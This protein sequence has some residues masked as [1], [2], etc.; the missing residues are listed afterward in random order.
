MV[1]KIKHLEDSIQES[2]VQWFNLQYKHLNGLLFHIPNGEY[3]ARIQNKNGDW[4][5]PA[6]VR[7]KKLGARRG[8]AD[9]FLM[10]SNKAYH[11]LWIEF[12]TKTGKL[13]DDQ[14]IFKQLCEHVN[15]KHEV[16]R[17]LD[18]GIISI[19]KYLM[20]I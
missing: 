9:I 7:L 19:K 5:C 2:F 20:N 3:R 10:L 17:S 16:A 18:D 15:Y 1:K 14:K 11:G 6:G 8:V 12:K 4:Y 13:T